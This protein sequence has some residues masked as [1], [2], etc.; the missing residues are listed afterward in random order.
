MYNEID[1][2][3]MIE[4]YKQAWGYAAFMAGVDKYYLTN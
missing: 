2:D 1:K 4:F 3:L